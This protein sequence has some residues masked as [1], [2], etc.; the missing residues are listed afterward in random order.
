MQQIVD[1]FSLV[2][3]TFD[4]PPKSI[5]LP[6]T[7][8]DGPWWTTEDNRVFTYLGSSVANTNSADLQV[9]RRIQSETK[10]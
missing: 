7:F 5:E 10:A 8:R 1:R 3:D 2:A 4:P 6:E 9:K